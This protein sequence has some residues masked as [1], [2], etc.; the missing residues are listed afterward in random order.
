LEIGVCKNK[1][2]VSMHRDLLADGAATHL[3][4]MKFDQAE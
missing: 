1:F 4:K 2:P 3:K